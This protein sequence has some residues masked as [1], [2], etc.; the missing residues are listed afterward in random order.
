M[1]S[2]TLNAQLDAAHRPVEHRGRGIALRIGGVS[3]FAAMMAALKYATLHGVGPAEILFYRNFFSL[4]TIILWVVLNGGVAVV[5]TK[6]PGAHAIRSALG[7]SVMFCTFVALS[8]LPLAEATVI[9]FSAPLFATILSALV[10][11]ERVLWHRWGAIAVGLLGVL[12]VI[13]PG[14]SGLPALGVAVALAAAL[15]AGGVTITLRQIGQTENAT[16]TVFWFNIACVIATAIPMPFLF[17]VHAPNVWAALTLGG[18]LG[19]IAQIMMTAAVRFAPVS[20]LAPFDYLQ[21]IW[22]MMWG[23]FLFDALPT[24]DGVLGAL[25][26]GSGG[27]YVIWRERKA[28]TVIVPSSNEL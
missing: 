4:P 24:W 20:A 8:M 7:L 10:L 9:S 17:H 25:L 18:L 28:R 6:R 23:F 2:A 5:R 12:V 13:R 3:C 14:G 15:G 16:A 21:M 27:C 26:I 1:S 22:A 19:G 11:K